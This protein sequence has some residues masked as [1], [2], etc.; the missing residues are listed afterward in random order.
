MRRLICSLPWKRLMGTILLIVAICSSLVAYSSVASAHET[1]LTAQQ[2]SEC[3][4]PPANIDVSTLSDIQLASYGFPKRPQ[5]ATVLARWQILVRHAKHRSCTSKPGVIRNVSQESSQN[6]SGNVAINGGY[7]EVVAY[8]DVPCVSSSPRN[9]FSSH[10]VGL[11]GDGN[12]G[13]GNL[14]QTGTE[15][16]TLSNG[17]PYYAAWYEDY[18]HDS[19]ENRVFNVSCNDEMYAQ[20]DSN[21]TVRNRA[22]MYIEDITTNTY[23]ASS[24]ETSLS[25]GSTAEWV[26]ERPTVNGSYAVLANFHSV[27]FYDALEYRQHY[28]NVG[29]SDHNYI[30][31]C[32]GGW[33]TCGPG[34]TQLMHPGPIVNNVTFPVYWDHQ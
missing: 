26:A 23:F 11:G 34:S 17:A 2:V 33:W 5:D 22:Y 30:I 18:P 12:D 14:V 6:W 4:Q 1:S 15:S 9:A 28:E 25:N 20:A 13:G 29:N 8:Y 7:Q 19:V 24:T 27:T 32:S 16:D 3:L 31:A 21:F 10:W